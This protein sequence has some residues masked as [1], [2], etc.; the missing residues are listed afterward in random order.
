MTWRVFV[1][2]GAAGYG[3]FSVF[4]SALFL[5]VGVL[6]GVQ[7]EATRAVAQ[8]D[9]ESVRA[10]VDGRRRGTSLIVF[11]L[12][13]AV[14]V[15]VVVIATSPLWA[16]A[17]LGADDAGLAW[18]V[19]IGAGFNCLVAAASGVMA[20]AGLWRQLAAIVALDGVLRVVLVLA[21]LA[22]GGSIVALAI[23][24]ILPFPLALA[25]VLASAP[26]AIL[27]RARVADGMGALAANTGRTMLAASAT[28]VLINGFPLVLSFFTT[29]AAHAGL[30]SLVLAVTLTR[31][32]ILVPLTALSSFLVNRFSHHPERVGRTLVLII[33]GLAAFAA[34]LCLCALLFGVPVMRFVFGAEFDLDA[35]SLSALVGSAALI[36][37]LSV[38]GS[39]V[40]ARGRHGWYAVGWVTASLITLA[41]LFVPLPLAP[42][43]A[44][45]LAA[46]P[47]I[48]LIVH[49]AA[50]RRRPVALEG[51]P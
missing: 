9:A 48:G 36:G 7:Q 13:L 51:N 40:L 14:V 37:A 41:L 20:G 23:A 34:V 15:V 32:P 49:L 25:A 38:T 30:G 2:A 45:A 3:I 35:G 29:S 27:S 19:A 6:F 24:V 26:R 39:A 5:V 11:S 22:S 1:E 17:S 46:G 16:P 28:A 4:W 33:G 50:L 8:T 31:A 10:V 47:A 44:L 21:V 12:V 18:F 42:R 43:A